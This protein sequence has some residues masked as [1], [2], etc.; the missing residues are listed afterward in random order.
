MQAEGNSGGGREV[1]DSK[2]RSVSVP[3]PKDEVSYWSDAASSKVRESSFFAKSF[4][5]N[6]M[7]S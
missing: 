7:I 1:A 6:M 4:E 3:Y 2:E 5:V